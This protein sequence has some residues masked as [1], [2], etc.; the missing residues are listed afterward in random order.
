MA[1]EILDS[2]ED[3]GWFNIKSPSGRIADTAVCNPEISAPEERAN[4]RLMAASPDLLEACRLLLAEVILSINGTTDIIPINVSGFGERWDKA[5]NAAIT[6]VK[7][8]T[9]GDLQ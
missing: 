2:G 4:A 7:K 8:A 3:Y 5:I 1:D 9:G 6:A